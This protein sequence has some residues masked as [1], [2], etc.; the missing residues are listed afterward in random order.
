MK[1]WQRHYSPSEHQGKQTS[2]AGEKGRG[3]IGEKRGDGRAGA[4]LSAHE[5]EGGAALLADGKLESE[6]SLGHAVPFGPHPNGQ[7]HRVENKSKKTKMLT[8]K[9][10][11]KQRKRGK[12][13]VK[14]ISY[15]PP[16]QLLRVLWWVLSPLLRSMG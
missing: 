4:L 16:H 2:K 10:K 15:T 3:V 12:L 7:F 8:N 9:A 6:L 14:T 11:V 1:P 13:D 5:H